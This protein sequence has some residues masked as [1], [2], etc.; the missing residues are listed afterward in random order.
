[1]SVPRGGTPPS[2]E[3]PTELIRAAISEA[4]P[5]RGAVIAGKYRLDRL[6]ARGGMGAVW[7]AWDSVLE[8]RV[9]V[10]FMDPDIAARPPLRARFNKEAKAA[11]RLRTPHVVQIIEH[12]VDGNTPYIVM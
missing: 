2:G 11:A 5:K 3:T 12:G 8:R 9:A 10:K 6:I 4:A 7:D 1:M